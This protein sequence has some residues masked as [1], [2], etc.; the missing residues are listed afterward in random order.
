MLLWLFDIELL[1]SYF[2]NNE[3][4]LINLR[5]LCLDSSV[6]VDQSENLNLY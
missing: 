5:L 2:T 6:V 3:I 1:E 4:K